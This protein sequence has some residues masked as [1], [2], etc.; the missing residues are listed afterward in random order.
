MFIFI[1]LDPLVLCS[2][3]DFLIYVCVHIFTNAC[4]DIDIHICVYIHVYVMF[5]DIFMLMFYSVLTHIHI[6]ICICV[7]V[8]T[9]VD[10]AV[11]LEFRS[12]YF[13]LIVTCGSIW[14]CCLMALLTAAVTIY[15]YDY[16]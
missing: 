7:C 9:H 2:C 4:S 14:R 12:F 8:N 6:F 1:V 3:I 11:V 5:A 16:C 10:N 13:A 15:Y